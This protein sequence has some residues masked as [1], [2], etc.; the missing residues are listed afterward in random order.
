[1]KE[2]TTINP[3]PEE[4]EAK[5]TETTQKPN[6]PYDDSSYENDYFPDYDEEDNEF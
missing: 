5:D 1:M 4:Q 6:A 2:N 3:E